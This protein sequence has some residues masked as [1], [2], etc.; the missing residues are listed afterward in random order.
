MSAAARST[1]RGTGRLARA[2]ANIARVAVL[3]ALLAAPAAAQAPGF[4]TNDWKR[5]ETAHFLVAYPEEL[6]DWALPMAQRLEAVHE[7]VAALVGHAPQDRTIVL[8]DDPSNVS[9]GMMVPGPLLYLWPAPPGP[10]S[11]V[12]ETRGWAEVLAVHEFAHAA[13]LTRPTRNPRLRFLWDLMPIPVYPI[14]VRTP[15]W[16]IEGYA[17]YVEG[18]LTGSGRPHGAWRPAVLRTWALEGQLPTYAALNGSSG[19][20]GGSMAYLVGSAYLEWL[21][22]REGRGERVLPDIWRRLTARQ[23]RSFDAAFD[24]VFGAPPTELYGLFAVDVT[25]RALA[26]RDA[27]AAAG[28][29]VDGELF[30]RLSW[31][32]GD[33]D[34]SPD[35]E[36][37]ALVLRARGQPSRL[38]VISTTPDTLTTEERQRRD[39]IFAADPEDVPPVE[40]R[41]RPQKPLA[42]LEPHAGREYARPAFMPDGQGILV[43]RDDVV[44]NARTRPDLFLWTWKTGE[45]RRITR[46]AAIHEADPA[47]DGSWAAALRCLH[48]HCDIVRVNLASGAL[49]T[50]ARADP[51]RPFYHPR[52]S[53]D[54][55][56]IVASMQDGNV[57]RLVAMNA[58]GSELRTIGP[59]DGASRFDAEF[60]PDGSA[61]VLTS[62]RGGIHD[63]E[64]IDLA[65]GTA[66]PVTRVIGAAVAPA[67]AAD[68]GVFF[69]SL[70]SRGWDL[71]RIRP[72]SVRIDADLALDP[73]LSPAAPV[74]PVAVDTFLPVPLG[75]VRGYG[76]GPRQRILLPLASIAVD[77]E[78]AGLALG[79]TDPI[80]IFSWQLQGMWGR[81][82]AWRGASARALWRGIRPWL[83]AEAFLAMQ[84]PPVP[85]AG[86]RLELEYAGGLAAL[87]LRRTRLTAAHVA[88]LAASAGRVDGEWGKDG[89]RYLGFGEYGLALVREPGRLRLLGSLRLHGAIGRTGDLEW[90][91]WIAGAAAS[92]R[93]RRAGLGLAFSGL[94]GATDAPV[95]SLESFAVGGTAPL[96]FDPSLLAQR[97]VMPALPVG[98]LR[99]DRVRT[100]RVELLG[101]RF[102]LT[103]FYWAGSVDGDTH[104]WYRVAGAELEASAGTVPFLRLPSIRLR[105]GIARTLDDPEE[106]EW[107]G[108]FTLGYRP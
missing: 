3:L 78:A 7:A 33:P 27:I 59:D 69:L 50:I 2:T 1:P 61:L 84:E 28:G 76:L 52:V 31:N 56:T 30:Q 20:Y 5:V 29:V 40:R 82:V 11:F 105:A 85:A 12:G 87:E 8:V 34:V 47:P 19:F 15:R 18:R 26:V 44:G 24:G 63:L 104:G 98:Q 80:G 92:I 81:E 103:P 86:E 107:R 10:R 65:T 73:S 55:R 32:T 9:N 67:P 95:R 64:R 21:V 25:R 48:G 38:V 16:A 4:S 100:A 37:L 22:K 13:H 42:T 41:P 53:P 102:P 96:L 54:G 89:G 51:L 77:G 94:Y 72:D 46:G 101:L 43:V 35:G 58:D 106:N 36:H 83:G 14:M 93:P 66:T 74:P 57:W 45:V 17:T 49:T 97:I 79:G 108:W 91:R 6:E 71:R 23:V 90:T 75:P 62:N 88:R 39:R 68:R 99:G 70:H 60:L